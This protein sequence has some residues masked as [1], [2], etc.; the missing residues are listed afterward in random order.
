MLLVSQ[1]EKERRIK[2]FILGFMFYGGDE[3]RHGEECEP[4]CQVKMAPHKSKYSTQSKRF[5]LK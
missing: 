3:I 4:C 5:G 2:V 1:L